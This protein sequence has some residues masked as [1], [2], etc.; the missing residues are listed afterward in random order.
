[1][2]KIAVIGSINIDL[3]VQSKRRPNKGETII[4]DSFSISPGGKGANQA[5]AA[6]KLG[7][8]TI[9]FGTLGNDQHG[10]YMLD[11]LDK[12]N[13]RTEYIQKNIEKESGVAIIHLAENDNSIVVVPGA[14]ENTSIEYLKSYQEILLQADIILIQLEIPIY[15]VEWAIDFLHQNNK[16]IILNPAPASKL[17][18]EVL[19][20]STYIIPNEHE[21]AIIFDSQKSTEELMREFSNKLIVTEG[22]RGVRFCDGTD[23]IH[24]PSIDVN[25]VD[26]TGAG[27]TFNGAIAVALAEGKSLEES[28]K[29][30]NVAAGISITKVG[31]QGGM[32]TRRELDKILR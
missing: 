8:E 2:A 11:I 24:I 3:V 23:I 21:C 27:D 4:G 6:S 7:A 32:I 16:T 25:V 26:T 12:Q 31:A 30:A 10:K 28:I 20:K 5:V 19:E 29:F 18:V 14:N 9:M 17:S 13:V 22:K 1:M 15:T